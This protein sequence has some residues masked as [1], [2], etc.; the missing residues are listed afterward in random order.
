M[1]KGVFI[2]R[3]GV[4]TWGLLMTLAFLGITIADHRN[5][6]GFVMVC[7]LVPLICLPGGYLFGVLVWNE[8]ERRYQ[9]YTMLREIRDRLRGA[10]PSWLPKGT[11]GDIYPGR[12]PYGPV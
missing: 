10:G 2:W 5:H 6:P 3:Y 11:S 1:R 8:T 9:A 4:L 7:L 12:L